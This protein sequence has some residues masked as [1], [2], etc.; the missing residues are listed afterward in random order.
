MNCHLIARNYADSKFI[1]ANKFALIPNRVP[2][3][4]C[5][6]LVQEQKENKEIS[7]TLEKKFVEEIGKCLSAISIFRQDMIFL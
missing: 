7:P 5:I 6:K 3:C 2:N 4:F 1:S